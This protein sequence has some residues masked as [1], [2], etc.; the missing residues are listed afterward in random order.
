MANK[1]WSTTQKGTY[2]GATAYTIGDFV[3]YVGSSYTC[4]ANTTGNLPTDTNYWA[5]VVSKGDAGTTGDTGAAGAQGDQGIQGIQGIQGDQGDQGAQ[6]IQG[7]QGDTG[8]T[9]ATGTGITEETVGF[10]ATGGTTPKTLTVALDA[11][12]AGT[13]TG[14][15]SN[16][17]VKTAYEANA[18]TNTYTDSEKTVVG[19][20]SNT[21]T[22]D[23]TTIVG[24]TGTKAEFDTAVT[25]GNIL[26][27]GDITVPVKAT[28]AEI[29]T[30]TDDAKF[31]TAKALEDQTT[32]AKLVSPTFTTPALGTPSAG[33]L[34]NA[35][36]LP[37]T[38]IANGTDGELITWSAAGVAT[39]VAVGT[40]AQVLTS[41][42]AG[43]APT[44]QA[45]AGGGGTPRMRASTT[46]ETAGR[47]LSANTAGGT[48]AF[49]IT[50]LTCTTSTTSASLSK[51]R[52]LAPTATIGSAVIGVEWS[53]GV[54]IDAIGTSGEYYLGFGS[55]DAT[56]SSHTFTDNH[57]G[58]KIIVSSGTATLYGTVGASGETTANLTTVTAGTFLDLIFYVTSSTTVDFYY[59]KNGGTLS[60]PSEVTGGQ[61]IIVDNT[62][63]QFSVNNAG[64][65]SNQSMKLSNASLER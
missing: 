1:L 62:M 24:I 16:A 28:G 34:T 6:G 44:F 41:N 36:G 63:F 15:M 9:G 4:I 23:Q 58:F 17:D 49:G 48:T 38:G 64:T 37:V 22:G 5:L 10:T 54:E 46:F 65:T 3:V 27:D 61:T 11:N 25:N 60:S 42:G 53:C 33:V 43:A 14:D 8:A 21:N 30:G 50:G 19:N 20:T 13:N 35:T 51:I 56:G 47:F 32:F 31:V 18:D 39:T 26:Y 12:V 59:R 2:A 45:A 7:I 55:I 57:I 52:M 40:A 29:D